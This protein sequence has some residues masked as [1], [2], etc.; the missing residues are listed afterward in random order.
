M[1]ICVFVMEHRRPVEIG[2]AEFLCAHP[3]EAYTRKLPSA[4]PELPASVA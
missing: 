2:E 4:T 3:L 1:V